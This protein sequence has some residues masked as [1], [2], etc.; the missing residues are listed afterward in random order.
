MRY[1]YV[2]V[3]MT[4]VASSIASA[5]DQRA[6]FNYMLHCQ[7]CHLPA[8]EGFAGKVPVMK[9]FVGYFL[10]SQEGREFLIRVPGV[11]H[12]ALSDGEIVELMN[13]LLQ[14]HSADQLPEPY[15][16]FTETEVAQLRQDPEGDPE[17]TRLR[18]LGQIAT[19]LPALASDMANNK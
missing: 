16:P 10:H 5:D 15:T 7:G 1:Q 17:R 13:W 2:L 3:F 18:I 6:H 4:F 19:E 11:S 8:A 14:T 12:S 9:D